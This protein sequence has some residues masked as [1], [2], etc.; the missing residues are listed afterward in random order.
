MNP[1]FNFADID[2]FCARGILDNFFR[3]MS[4]GGK[5]TRL[6]RVVCQ[7]IGSTL[8]VKQK[9]PL[10]DVHFAGPRHGLGLGVEFERAFTDAEPPIPGNSLHI[11]TL[12]YQLGHLKCVVN[13]EV[14]AF[15][16]VDEASDTPATHQLNPSAKQLIEEKPLA[17][18]LS[19]V[20]S[21]YIIDSSQL[22]EIKTSLFNGSHNIHTKT[23]TSE[24]AA[25]AFFSSILRELVGLHTAGRNTFKWLKEIDRPEGIS[26]WAYNQRIN[27]QLVVSLLVRLRLA[28]HRSKHGV[29]VAMCL[30]GFKKHMKIYEPEFD[31]VKLNLELTP[32][33][34]R[35]PKTLIPQEYVNLFWR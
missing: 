1:D 22:R 21:G 8:I 34:Y 25:Q 9:A 20:R 28:T 30:P 18:D 13:V 3:L 33:V 11:R 23:K 10:P 15:D 24:H 7:L 17:G 31:K 4:G 16:P 14:D 29:C 5:G 35:I 32:S 12:L 26:D 6:I 27:L 19:V 2:I